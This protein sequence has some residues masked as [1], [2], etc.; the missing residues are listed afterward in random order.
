MINII[1]TSPF[2]KRNKRETGGAGLGVKSEAKKKD[3]K[4]L[5]S[6]CYIKD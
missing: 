6:V 5:V 2:F 3:K 1:L 4:H